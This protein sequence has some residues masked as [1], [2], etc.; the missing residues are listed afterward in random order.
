MMF[1]SI[2]TDVEKIVLMQCLFQFWITGVTVGIFISFLR[3]VKAPL[4]RSKELAAF[5][6]HGLDRQQKQRCYYICIFVI[7]KRA[8]IT[9]FTKRKTEHVADLT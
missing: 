7:M 6:S 3:C 5:D 9:S 2:G 4:P 1:S 8:V